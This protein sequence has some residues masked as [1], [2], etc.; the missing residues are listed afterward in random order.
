VLVVPR[1]ADD[2]DTITVLGEAVD[3]RDQARGSR[4]GVSPL[5]AGEICRDDRRALLVA[6]ADDVVEDVGGAGIARQ[7]TEL[8][9]NSRSGLV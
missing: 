8:V 9:E 6:T 3:E 2:L 4:E 1:R 5:L 7:V